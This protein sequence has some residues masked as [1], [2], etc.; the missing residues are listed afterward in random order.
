MIRERSCMTCGGTG[1]QWLDNSWLKQDGQ[2]REQCGI[3]G[4]SGKSNFHNYD[5]A[6]VKL[7]TARRLQHSQSRL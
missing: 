6:F 1:W 3:C 7:Q 5:Y 2:R 4:G